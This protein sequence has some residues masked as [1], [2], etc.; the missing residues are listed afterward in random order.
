MLPQKIPLP[1]FPEDRIMNSHE[2]TV[3]LVCGL[4]TC[5]S[6]L[7]SVLLSWL[8]TDIRNLASALTSAR[9]E[10]N[11]Q[12]EQFRQETSE[13]RQAIDH[14]TGVLEGKGII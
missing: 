1:K 7:A 9:Q 6:G 12:G 10:I 11:G 3:Y 4:A 13:L 8:R 5:V 2:L 14:L